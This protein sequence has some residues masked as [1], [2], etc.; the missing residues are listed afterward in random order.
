MRLLHK[1]Q[2][3][4]GA[5]NVPTTQGFTGRPGFNST[6][7]GWYVE[8]QPNNIFPLRKRS[9]GYT[10][11]FTHQACPVLWDKH[12]L[13]G[14]ADQWKK[15]L[16]IKIS[17]HTHESAVCG[18]TMIWPRKGWGGH[19]C[20][21]TDVCLLRKRTENGAAVCSVY[22]SRLLRCKRRLHPRTHQPQKDK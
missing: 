1:I 15:A 8:Y 21:P 13:F 18:K 19:R 2:C 4:W 9:I 14:R 22:L 3:R 7:T 12:W 16:P 6:G 17:R 5:F 20:F 10:K 11:Y